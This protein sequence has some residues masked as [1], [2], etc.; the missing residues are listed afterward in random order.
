MPYTDGR[1]LDIEISCTVD[2]ACFDAALMRHAVI[3]LANNAFKYSVGNVPPKLTVFNTDGLL[4]IV[5][6]DYGIGIPSV[7]K[8]KIFNSFYRASNVGNISGTGIGLMLVDYAVK[9][10]KGNIEVHSSI[11]EG[12]EYT[13]QIPL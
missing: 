13:I 7:D 11:N 5:V 8:E 1:N 9:T 3:N 6:K 4:N 10:H 2:C 12:S